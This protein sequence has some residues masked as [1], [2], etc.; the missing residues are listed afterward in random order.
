MVFHAKH[1]KNFIIDFHKKTITI[2]NAKVLDENKNWIIKNPKSFSGNRTILLS[3]FLCQTLQDTK[4]IQKYAKND[5]VLSVKPN[6]ITNTFPKLLKKANLPS[7]R[8]H[9]LRHFHASMMLALNIPDKYATIRNFFAF[10][11]NRSYFL[12]SCFF[13]VCFA[14]P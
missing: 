10:S 13:C 4:K 11:E 6:T 2:S 1:E 3:E 8:F 14:N 5:F 9:D 12:Y 7:F